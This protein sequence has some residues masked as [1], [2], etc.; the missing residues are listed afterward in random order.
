MDDRR[1]SV[2]IDL[3]H[4]NPHALILSYQD[5]IRIIVKSYIG[6]GMFPPADL[7]DIV[8]H[9]NR[10][11]L[12]RI[13]RIRSQYNGTSLFRTYLSNIIRNS[14]LSLRKQRARQPSFVEIDESRLPPGPSDV[15][16]DLLIEQDILTFRAIIEQFYSERFKLLLCLKI[17]YRI[18]IQRQDIITW[19]RACPENDMTVLIT[20]TRDH[21]KKITDIQAF[22]LLKP[23]VNK[24]ENTS[25]SAASIRRWTDER[26]RVILRLL[27]G[28]PPRSAHTRETLGILLEDMFA[29]FLLD[30]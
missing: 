22:E 8:Q 1:N 28:S 2:D 4:S 18:P 10:E 27:N 19:W 11:L 24:A 16:K 26:I 12:E 9:V 6:S 21:G 7:E 25:S 20:A 14:C 17:F 3:L 13:A 5:T 29:P 23:L 30:R 15:D